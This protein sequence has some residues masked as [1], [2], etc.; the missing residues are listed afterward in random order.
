[1]IW[2]TDVAAVRFRILSHRATPPVAAQNPEIWEV[3]APEGRVG[4]APVVQ[5]DRVG[6]ALEVRL[7]P[8]VPE[9]RCPDGHPP[10]ADHQVV[11]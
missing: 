2:K 4:Q 8:E 6:R 5:A 9:D 1:M 10:D 11:A 7:V 3:R